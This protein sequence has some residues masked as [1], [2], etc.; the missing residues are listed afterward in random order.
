MKSNDYVKYLTEQFVQY[1]EQ[2]KE[3]R[4]SSRRERKQNNTP[5]IGNRWFGML[6]VAFNH[7]IR[8]AKQKSPDLKEKFK[9]KGNRS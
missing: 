4:K 7:Y 5:M 2:P 9:R 1:V 6:P 3:Q 8:H